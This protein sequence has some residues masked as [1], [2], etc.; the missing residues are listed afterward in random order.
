M[1]L[2]VVP[3]EEPYQASVINLILP[4]QQ[5]EFG[6]SITIQDQPD[7]LNICSFYFKGNGG[8]WVAA[9]GNRVVGTVA[10]ADIGNQ[11]GALRKMFVHKDYRGKEKGTAQLLMNALLDWAKQKKITQVYL[12]TI[13][14]MLAAHQFYRKNG[15]MEI[16]K[17]QLPVAFPV[18][19]VDNRFFVARVSS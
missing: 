12:G 5:Q 16:T 19:V 11:Q 15:F 1:T 13:D 9:D 14:T 2:V 7:L 4:I 10:L 17:S 8:F 18:M 3:Y 6:V